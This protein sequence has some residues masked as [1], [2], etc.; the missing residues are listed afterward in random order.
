MSGTRVTTII[1]LAV[2]TVLGVAAFWTAR[3]ICPTC[4]QGHGGGDPQSEIA[5]MRS[6]F[7]LT[8][9]EFHKIEQ[10]HI[11]YVPECDEYCR[12]VAETGREVNRLAASGEAMTDEIATAIRENE[13]TRADC[14]QA[15]LDHLYETAGAMP[16]EK[17][18]RFLD[19]ALSKVLSPE[20]PDVHSAVSH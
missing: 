3:L 8:E 5:W 20:H 2:A 18:R 9:E 16:P 10:L 4:F 7:E 1:L 6:E 13:R 11:A 12:R 17:G 19:M 15:L 14:L